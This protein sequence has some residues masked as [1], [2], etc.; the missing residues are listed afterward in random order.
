ML[1]YYE[2]AVN[3]NGVLKHN[4]RSLHC[5]TYTLMDE[6][7]ENQTQLA[8]ELKLRKGEYESLMGFNPRGV[9]FQITV[10]WNDGDYIKKFLC[11]DPV[12]GKTVEYPIERMGEIRCAY[13]YDDE[14]YYITNVTENKSIVYR[15]TPYGCTELCTTRKKETVSGIIADATRVAWQF[16][17]RR[18]GEEGQRLY[19]FD[20]QNVQLS[21]VSVPFAFELKLVNLAQNTVYTTLTKRE[22]EHLGVSGY[23]SLILRSLD[24]LTEGSW[25]VYRNSQKPVLWN[26]SNRSISYLDGSVCYRGYG[27]RIDRCDRDGTEHVLGAT[28]H[29]ECEKILVTD[30]W[31]YINYDAYDLVRLP[32]AF[33]ECKELASHNPEAFF[34]FGQHQDFR[35]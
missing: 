20:K 1:K 30:K 4:E 7:G 9:W 21:S 22:R 33:S 5:H 6:N 13:I 17:S 28:G 29:G 2:M 14:I 12:S 10:S 32:K 26:L 19:L 18:D 27:H 23:D 31:L 24:H 3:R 11:V 15:H 35:M 8:L 16:E 25:R 34:L